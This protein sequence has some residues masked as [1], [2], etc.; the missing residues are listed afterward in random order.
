MGSNPSGGKG[1]RDAAIRTDLPHIA[2]LY[3]YYLGGKDN[4]AADRRFAEKVLKVFPSMPWAAK[5]NRAF[6]NRATRHLVDV[7]IR[8]FLDVGTGIPTE[9][10]LHQVAQE[11][12]PDSRVVYVDNDPLVMTHARALLVSSPQGRTEYVFADVRNPHDIL[13]APEIRDTL[14]LTQPVA[15]SLVALL[16]FIP[17]ECDPYGIVATLVEA[18]A[19][20]SYLV[21]SHATGDFIERNVTASGIGLCRRPDITIQ[22]RN[23]EEFSRF[24]AGLELVEPGIVLTHRW[25]TGI[26]SPSSRD[27]D[28]IFYAAVA[29]KL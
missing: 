17:D 4:Y 2:R 21:I 12:A 8:Q 1:Y 26:E 19:S 11:A 15:L 29:R 27:S 16:H 28:A 24:F 23:R 5:A 14:D 13:D 9:P 3:D 6:M 10:N 25:R 22:A 18:L 20:G 7:G